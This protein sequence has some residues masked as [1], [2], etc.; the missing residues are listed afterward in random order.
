MR[1]P[2][3]NSLGAETAL[4]NVNISKGDLKIQR[5]M[6]SDMP[7]GGGGTRSFVGILV[8]PFRPL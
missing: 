3:S 4:V 5:L 6:L 8:T 7:N 1:I 2:I